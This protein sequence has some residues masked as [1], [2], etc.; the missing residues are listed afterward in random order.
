MYINEERE[1]ESGKD[2]VGEG[3]PTELCYTLYSSTQ[4]DLYIMSRYK[5]SDA[6]K[7][8]RGERER[9]R[10]KNSSKVNV[11]VLNTV[12]IR[13]SSTRGDSHVVRS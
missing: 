1:R 8:E 11:Y 10:K 9:E 12:Y 5:L 7:L 13:H 6:N 4:C 2:S 3:K